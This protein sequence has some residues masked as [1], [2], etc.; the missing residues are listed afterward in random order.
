[1]YIG[2]NIKINIKMGGELSADEWS[3]H[4]IQH[5]RDDN[6]TELSRNVHF[7]KNVGT[8]TPDKLA[9]LPSWIQKTLSTIAP[10]IAFDALVLDDI[11]CLIETWLIRQIVESF[12]E[13]SRIYAGVQE[14][15]YIP[16]HFADTAFLWSWIVHMKET[17]TDKR[18]QAFYTTCMVYLS[19]REDL[20][21]RKAEGWKDTLSNGEVAKV[22]MAIYR[23]G[24]AIGAEIGDLLAKMCLVIYTDA[25]PVE[26]QTKTLDEME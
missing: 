18:L 19:V 17:T 2:F 23:N 14:G 22:A 1:M 12:E 24:G 6:P 7:F 10:E 4:L 15:W 20:Y 13:L 3:Q 26:N 9:E 21:M 16:D 5:L 11:R 8:L 25:R